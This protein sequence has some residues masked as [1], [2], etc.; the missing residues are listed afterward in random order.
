[1]TQ[2]HLRC[3]RRRRQIRTFSVAAVNSSKQT[4]FSL[5]ECQLIR[6]LECGPMPNVMVTLPN[7]GGALFST[8]QS[9]F[10]KVFFRLSV[11]AS[12]AKIQPDK[13]VPKWRFFASCIFS[14]PRAAHFRHEF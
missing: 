13:V 8:P 3:R 11:H 1:M 9:L 5:T 7:I 4:C 6:K 12:A 2:R 10:N 14:E